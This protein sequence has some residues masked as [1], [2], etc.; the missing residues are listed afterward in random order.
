MDA[1]LKKILRALSLELRHILE[2]QYSEDGKWHAGD[3]E[4][5]LNQIGIWW[6]RDPKPISEMPNL[7]P[8]D[9]H[10]RELIDAYLS[11]RKE[12]GV[13]Q[14]DAVSEFVRESAYSWAN[15]LFALRCMEA[16]EIIDP[17]ILQEES[18]GG[19]SM[20]HNRFAQRNPTQCTGEDDGLFA[21]LFEEFRER[22]A[23]LPD[24]FTPDS[25]AVAL[26]PS[27]AAL[28]KCIGILSGSIPANGGRATDEVFKAPDAFGWSYQYWNAEEKDR[29]FEM[30]RTKKGAKIE[31][32]DIIPATQLYTEPYMVKFLVQNSL[33]A[34]WMMM[35]PESK[36]SAA[37]EYY[38]KDV[39]RTPNEIKPVAEITFLDPACGSGHFL[40]EAFD[41]LYVMY[42]EEGQTKEP[43]AI[44]RSILNNNLFGIDIDE[45]AIQITKAVLWMKA[46]E[47]VFTKIKQQLT[48][49]NLLEFHEHNIATNIRL[50]NGKDHLDAFLKKHPEDTPLRLALLTV[51]EGLQ[52]VHELG[53]LVQ[54]EEPV[55]KELKVLKEQAKQQKFDPESGEVVE[56]VNFP[57]WKQQVMK[58]L[59]AHFQDEAEKA[60][61]TEA[62]FSQSAVKGL[63]L[64]DLLARRYAVVVA[65]PPFMGSKNMN[66]RVKNYIE[67]NY[68][69]GRKDLYIF[70]ILRNLQ[71][72]EKNGRIAMVT[73]QSWL[74]LPSYAS[75]RVGNLKKSSKSD[76]VFDGLLNCNRIELL[77][78]LGPKAFS[79]ISGEVV[80][81]ALFIA[82]N[83][84]NIST[85]K[86]VSFRLISLKDAKSKEIGLIESLKNLKSINR[87]SIEQKK[88]SSLPNAPIIYW[89][90]ESFLSLLITQ[91][92]LR[93][94][95]IARAVPGLQTGN[96][97]R[98][99]R[100]FWET[101]EPT[102]WYQ[103][104]KG[105]GYFRWLGGDNLSIDWQYE[106]VR[107]RT[108][109]L[110][111][112]NQG[113][114]TE[115]NSK[116]WNMS[117]YKKI[118]L[119]Y[120]TISNGKIGVRFKGA[121]SLFDNKGAGIFSLN[122]YPNN[123][124]YLA[125]LFNSHLATYI[126]R[127]LSG[128]LDFSPGV[129]EKFPV[130]IKNE[131]NS[132]I[133]NIQTILKLKTFEKK[134]DPLSP[135]FAGFVNKIN[136][137]NSFK[138]SVLLAIY[139]EKNE[140]MINNIYCT[141]NKNVLDIFSETGTPVGFF[142]LIVN[143]DSKPQLSGD[144]SQSIS[145]FFLNPYEHDYLTLTLGEIEEIKKRLHILYEAG[146]GVKEEAEDTEISTSDGED[147][148]IAIGTRIPIPA[149]T[150]LEE[151]SYKMEI[152]PISIY[153][154]LKEGIEKENWR[155]IPEEKR[156]IEDFFTVMILR[157]LGHRWPKQNDSEDPVS[158]CADSDGIIPITSGLPHK[159]LLQLIRDRIPIEFP[160][161]KVHE[162]E[163]EF[164]EVV[165][166]PLER[167]LASEFF[168]H[169]ISQFKK[170]PI[171]WQLSSSSTTTMR[172]KSK[173]WGIRREPA[174]SCII[175][176]H[177]IDADILHKIISQYVGDLVNR[178]RT[179]IRA[180]EGQEKLTEDQ[181]VRKVQ[182]ENLI[183]ELTDFSN[184]LQNVA[185]TGFDSP[186]L[187]E[188]VKNEPIDKWIS[189]NGK[190][191]N[192]NTSDEFHAQEKRYYPDIN[193]G[194]RVNIAPLQKA[195]L[196]STDVI[197]KKDVDEA[198]K[199][200][201]EWRADER[202]WCREGKVPK[203]GWWGV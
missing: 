160:E 106:G 200:R 184:T 45:R 95:N 93:N 198:I 7:S 72:L 49:D 37:W 199:D 16:R 66:Q 41:I 203:P 161:I 135:N 181:D 166:I 124:Y 194:V 77:A 153:W 33:G 159:T 146:P 174:F 42:E 193:D 99:L 176:Y 36:L 84:P 92:S 15:R 52:N 44:C 121:N 154:L 186:I 85:H 130:P 126:L 162:I 13:S 100:F 39:D 107:I 172:R 113:K 125:G 40:L 151:L 10:A 80:N 38:V 29:V 25:P 112:F 83:R 139:E 78:H 196:L 71:L 158:D 53:S 2:G 21:M 76:K 19:R 65:N 67:N 86:I 31:G 20:V 75:I 183:D 152:H 58:R 32:A 175:Y 14:S 169:H 180:L 23:E 63:A 34:T 43:A 8:V 178:Y 68:Q 79:E 47:I 48:G 157:L 170:R 190:V 46:A 115:N 197:A 57:R 188:I 61:P 73:Q 12:A 179:E 4:R 50:P 136:V 90:D 1:Q 123:H 94:T 155:C 189:L 98:H 156:H 165:G 149:E 87:F 55:E 9:Q 64:F 56:K 24:L 128:V 11:L 82:M 173:G 97:P 192:S 201:A 131:Q 144:L 81:V 104:H 132:I 101:N 35:H 118:G 96:N 3:L 177:K 163:K 109:K 5:R 142:P 111:L 26:R 119:T 202:R 51:F 120:T 110:D 150:F 168:K 28:K 187:K 105:L 102:R 143:Y 117:W 18:Y 164:E 70:F 22:S 114:I 137:E 129:V 122:N 148:K 59:K 133:D 116:C 62:F 27:V 127:L 103:Y 30:V 145:E 108:E 134:S 6:D 185:D 140:R 141:D 60:L 191:Q 167:W 91:P 171:A 138:L 89:I 17:V 74:F 182:L 147:E 195:G 69:K 54:I 88:L